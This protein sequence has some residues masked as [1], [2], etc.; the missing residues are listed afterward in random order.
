MYRNLLRKTL[1]DLRTSLAQTIALIVIVAL[2]ITSLIALISAYRDLST[3]YNHTYDQ[4]HFDDADF[5]INRSPAAVAGQVA[6]VDGVAAVTGRLVVDAGMQLPPGADSGAGNQIR[7]R[8]IGIPSDRHPEVNDLLVL[9]GN[10]LPAEGGAAVL[11]ESHFADVYGL[12]PGDTVSPL[13]DG[14]AMPLKVAGTAA[15]P[16]YLIVSPSRQEV[17]PS[18]S[19]FA[20]LFVPLA[21][22][23]RITNAGNTVNDIVVTFKPDADPARL[24]A[25]IQ[26][27]LVPYGLSETTPRAEQPSYAALKLDLDGYRQ[28]AVLMPLLILLVAAGSVY[29]MLARQVRAQRP[30]IGLMK[31]LGYTKTA[32]VLHYLTF[33]LCLAVAGSI[34]GV[35]A[36]FPLARWLTGA[37]ATELGIPLVQTKLYIDLVV[38]GVLLSVFVALAAGLGPV[39][40]SARA[41]PAVAMRMDPA[42]TLTTGRPTLIERFIHMPF[43]L[44]LPVR[45]VFRVRRRSLSTGIGVVFS[46]ILVLTGWSFIGSMSYLLSHNFNDIERW[47]M[48]AS[49]DRLLTAPDL[50]QIQGTEGVRQAVPAVQLPASVGNA[51]GSK[52]VLLTAVPP[53]QTMHSFQ[54]QG[55]VTPAEALS[56]GKI[57][58]TSRI[59]DDLGIK[60]GDNVDVETTQGKQTLAVGGLSDELNSS[61]AYMSLDEF[62]RWT[63]SPEPRFNFTYLTADSAKS[64]DI[65]ASLYRIPGASSVQFKS[66]I[67]SDWRS[68]LGFFNIFMAVILGFA[69]VMSFALLFNAMTVNV[70]EQQREFAT[71]RSVGVGR[72][73]IALQMAVETAIVWLL[74]LV[75]G[76]LLGR[77]V[78]MWMAGSFQSDLLNFQITVTPANYILTAAGILI[79]M[80]LAS[81]PAI[82]RVNRLNLADAT[83]VYT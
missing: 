32:V 69:L 15:S 17:F 52:E 9:K 6:A 40:V 34:L 26:A 29:V 55:G 24:T 8:L 61:V 14:R 50:A 59:A 1:R 83:K 3:S 25:A 2:G 20:V 39:L 70:L 66:A 19:T 57:I 13:I 67:E 16:E 80:L 44:R 31:A 54:L 77:L 76:L 4:L 74:A 64:N 75:P 7:S 62:Q 36:G 82:R 72:L 81:L 43:W 42:A 58:L 68:L 28:I 49:F 48:T 23:Q 30:Q 33:A 60:T 21:D 71:M 63:G 79:T 27:I 47:D 10:Y 38:Y 18:A 41:L 78:A 46:F 51:G 22:L 65:E 73:R 5:V 53:D 12:G 56:P 37:Y 35:A 45:N 11:L